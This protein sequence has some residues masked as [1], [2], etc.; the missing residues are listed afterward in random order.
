MAFQIYDTDQLLTVMEEQEPVSNYWLDL[1]FPNVLTFTDQWID[2]EQIPSQGR[3]LMP[4]VAPLAQGRPIYSAGSKT[5]RF[6]PSYMKAKDP[7]TPTRAYARRPGTILQ[8]VP[9][10]P[11]RRYDAWVGDCTAF[12][13]TAAE[14]TWEW[15]AAQS[16]LYGAVTITDEDAPTQVVDFQRAAGHNITLGAGSRWGD[17]GISIMD[18]IQTWKDLLYNAEFGGIAARL[19][20][21]TSAW[22]KMRK[23]PEIKDLLDVNYRSQPTDIRIERGLISSLEAQ[24]VGNLGEGIDVYVYR[25][26]YTVGGVQTPFMDSRDV[27]LTC[28]NV[29]GYRCFG[30]IM[31]PNAEY[32]PLPIH[33]RMLMEQDPAVPQ[34]L[35]QS[36]P[37][38]VPTMPNATLRARVVA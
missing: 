20:V 10:T 14:R 30:A 23:D 32:A 22:A 35:T 12:H 15:L 27:V 19:T 37:L 4:F 3:K 31:D 18:N 25:D 8:K 1:C 7:F 21:G 33:T 9:E 2:M 16:I 34:I 24:W 11:A 13:R 5:S 6:K 17:A 29:G 26:W 28:G 38:P 36:A